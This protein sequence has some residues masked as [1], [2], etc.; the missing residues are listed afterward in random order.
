MKKSMMAAALVALLGS[1]HVVQAHEVIA[2]RGAS[3]YLPEHTLE[4]VILAHGMDVDYIEQD[5]VVSKDDHLV[6][7]HDIYLDKVTDVASKFPER[8]RADGRFYAVDFTLAEL[9]QLRVNARQGE[10]TRQVQLSSDERAGMF[11]ISTFAEQVA[12]IQQLNAGRDRAIGF[13]PEVK[14]PAWHRREGKDISRLLVTALESY[15]LNHSD[16]KI[17]VQCFDFSEVQ[18]L[19]NEVGLKTGLVQLLGEASWGN[20]ESDYAWLQTA[21]GLAEIAKVAQGVGPWHRQLY[22]PRT[23]EVSA[24]AKQAKQQGLLI[25]PY[26]VNFDNAPE[27]MSFAEL[28]Q[29]LFEQVKVDAVFTDY[30][31]RIQR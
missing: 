10:Q 16:A 3:G 12:L 24:F 29:V 23:Q 27:G 5:L 28:E 17:M 18:R 20:P 8:K 7:L 31:D 22:D 4:A 30:A 1:M 15:G 2:H 6:V 21:E 11:R 14:Q 19:R 26:T 9:K 25:H 13:Y